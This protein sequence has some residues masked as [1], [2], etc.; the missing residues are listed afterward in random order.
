MSDTAGHTHSIEH[1]LKLSSTGSKTATASLIRVEH[2]CPAQTSLLHDKFP[3]SVYSYISILSA[4]LYLSRGTLNEC[5]SSYA[6]ILQVNVSISCFKI[7]AIH[8]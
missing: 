7:S 5:T 3:V 4:Y 2:I 1:L 6:R 8:D